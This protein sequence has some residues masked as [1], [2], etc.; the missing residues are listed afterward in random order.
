LKA[1][2]TSYLGGGVNGNQRHER[3]G[4]SL[5]P[6]TR[7]KLGMV[8]PFLALKGVDGRGNLIERW[9]TMKK[10]GRFYGRGGFLLT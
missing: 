8:N 6:P 2:V 4:L 1:T 9:S 5:D 10:H 3:K 7:D